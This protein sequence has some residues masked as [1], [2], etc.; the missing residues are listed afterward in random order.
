MQAY[1]NN[2][3]RIEDQQIDNSNKDKSI[4]SSTMHNTTTN[5][6]S[7]HHKSS[8][9]ML[10]HSKQNGKLDIRGQ[11]S[12]GHFYKKE[13]YFND[14]VEMMAQ[15]KSSKC[16]TRHNFLQFCKKFLTFMIS[17]IG[18]MIVMIGYVL[19]GGK[20]FE[21]LES[22]NEIASI[23]LGQAV[24]EQVLQKIYRQIETNSTRIRDD[25]FNQ[26]LKYEIKY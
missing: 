24:I 21:V 23:K 1:S 17:R 19:A 12:G 25:T 16:C 18:L 2:K 26:F 13:D 5:N 4:S 3:K 14:S 9:L 6:K 11:G 7:I 20:I 8:N 22:E 10:Y 15:K